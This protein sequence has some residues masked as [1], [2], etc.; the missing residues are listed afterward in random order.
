MLRRSHSHRF[1]WKRNRDEG[2]EKT[3]IVVIDT[4]L[5]QITEEQV[6]VF[7]KEASNIVRH[8]SSVMHQSELLPNAANC[9]FFLLK[10]TACA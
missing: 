6:I 9:S 7:V 8:V 5:F 10:E 2:I 1:Q 3:K 4:Y